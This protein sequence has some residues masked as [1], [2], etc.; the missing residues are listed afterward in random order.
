MSQ[1]INIVEQ[2]DLA[3]RDLDL[4]LEMISVS[5]HHSHRADCSDIA[6]LGIRLRNWLFRLRS[7]VSWPGARL[8]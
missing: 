5:S 6:P 3:G 8:I 2:Q 7:Q 4:F 1:K